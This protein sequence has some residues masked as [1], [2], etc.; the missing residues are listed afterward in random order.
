MN[1]LSLARLWAVMAKEFI[2]MRRDRLTFAMMLGIP[3]LQLTLFGYAINTDPKHLPTAVVVHQSNEFTRAILQ[4]IE[5]TGYFHLLPR[6]IPESE[7]DELLKQGRVQFVI[8][9]P[10]RF[11]Q[12]LVR[13]EK[14]AVLVAA[15]ATDPVAS[16]N[17]LAAIAELPRLHLAGIGVPRGEGPL[18]EL[19][20]HRRYNP[21]GITQYNIVP[22]LMGV[23]LTM[24]MVLVTAVAITREHEKGTMEYLLVT[25]IHPGEVMLGK[26]IP[27]IFVGYMQIALILLAAVSLFHVPIRGSV[28]LVLLLMLPFIAANLGMGITFSTLAK[29]QMQAMQMSFFFFLPSI[30]LSGFM[31]PFRGM[32]EWAQWLGEALPLT[33]FLRIVRGVLLKGSELS[34][35]APEIWPILIFFGFAM[36]LAAIRYRRTLD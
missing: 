28:S 25:P 30:L 3:I 23:I 13:G 21:E 15:D 1:G 9:F 18:F 12:K 17:A 31:F 32:P 14:P 29:N 20:I 26:L 22:G 27:Y 36:G 35:V 24:T 4:A 16:G 7:A 5:H 34:E 19:R 33:H 11:A 6:Q 10:V 2:Q 8:Q